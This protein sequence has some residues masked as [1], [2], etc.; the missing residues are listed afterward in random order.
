MHK[1]KLIAVC[2]AMLFMTSTGFAQ[3]QP[4]TKMASASELF[5]A[6]KW[7]EAAQAY[8]DVVKDQ[9]NN[10]VAMY[11]AAC[12]YARLKQNDKALDWL[13]KALN[14]RLPPAVNPAVDEDLQGLRDD[15]RFKELTTAFDRKRRPCMYS[16]EA[17]QFD[18]WVGEWNVFN[19]QGQQVGTSVIQQIANGCG[20]LEN[21]S[22]GGKSLNFYD[23][24]EGKWFQYWIGAT[25]VPQRY[26]G[27]YKDGA[28]RYESETTQPNGTKTCQRLT[29]FNADGS[30]RQLAEQS[31]DGA[32]WQVLYD[33]KYM[34]KK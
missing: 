23:S 21:W 17:R 24:R 28:M 13:S 16:S 7:A 9:P 34:R 14:G 1:T 33:F 11:N 18:F 20:I 30:V 5:Q 3:T 6:K 12:A 4:S 19:A 27:N 26:S 8:E 2:C 10:A 15:V 31:S 22:G 32:T 25:G 29:F